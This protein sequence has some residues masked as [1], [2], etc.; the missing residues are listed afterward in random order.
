MHEHHLPGT[1]ENCSDDHCPSGKRNRYFKSKYL[2]AKD[3]VIEQGYGIERRRLL[4]RA[5]LGWGVAYGFHLHVSQESA[6][7]PGQRHESAGHRLL[8]CG[9][10]LA[11]DRHGRELF[12][13]SAG[14]LAPGEILLLDGN[15]NPAEQPP[16]GGRFL[17]QAHYAEKGVD[18]IRIGESCDCYEWDHLCET[19]IFSLRPLCDEG[20]CPGAEPPCPK[21]H[22]PPPR[23]LP[24]EDLR[25]GGERACEGGAGIDRGPHRCLCEWLAHKD[26]HI[27]A[28]PDCLCDWNGFAVALNDAVPLAC[29]RVGFDPCG[30]PVFECVDDACKPRRLVKT[31]DLLFDLVRGCDLT[32]ISGLSWAEWHRN[33]LS[34]EGFEA[35]FPRPERGHEREERDRPEYSRPVRTRFSV[36]FSGPVQIDTL[37]PECVAMTVLAPQERTGWLETLRVPV[38][39]IECEPPRAGDP[40]NT[41]RE[42]TLCVDA[43]WCDDEIWDRTSIFRRDET[44]VEI[45]IRGDLILDCCGQAVDANSV[46]R[47]ATPSGN[48]TPGGTNIST[49]RVSAREGEGYPRA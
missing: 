31:N 35:M 7:N 41:T 27:P 15:G 38:T 13:A 30:H 8:R 16:E 11:L 45:E 24:R 14:P 44:Q 21:C 26:K 48:G 39:A 20:G 28:S 36:T 22:C 18:K 37:T 42:A 9:E 17:L 23:E 49:F 33:G 2:K 40:Q 3:F 29:V 32:R 47:R 6:D 46:G 25:Q 4:N 12:R 43:D 34:W 10:G 19:V 1:D 5:V